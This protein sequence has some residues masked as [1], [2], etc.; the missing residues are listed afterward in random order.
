VSVHGSGHDDSR[1]EYVTLVLRRAESQ[2]TGIILN[3]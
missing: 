2:T 3:I 1:Y